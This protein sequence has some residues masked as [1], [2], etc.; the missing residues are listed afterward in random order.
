MDVQMAM[1]MNENMKLAGVEN[2]GAGHLE[3]ETETWERGGTQE[4]IGV[5]L[6]VI[7]TSGL[8]NLKRPPLVTKQ[9]PKCRYSHTNTSTNLLTKILSCL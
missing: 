3:N 4:S 5:T 7:T 2:M 8:W 1:N 6:S 9:E